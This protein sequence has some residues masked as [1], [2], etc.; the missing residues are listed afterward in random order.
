MKEA[1]TGLG[2]IGFIGLRDQGTKQAEFTRSLSIYS[3]LGCLEGWQTHIVCRV[4]IIHASLRAGL[5]KLAE[6]QR[7]L[8]CMRQQ[9]VVASCSDAP[10]R[11]ERASGLECRE[12]M[13]DCWSTFAKGE[14]RTSGGLVRR[15]LQRSPKRACIAAWY[16]PRRIRRPA[17]AWHCWNSFHVKGRSVAGWATSCGAGGKVSWKLVRAAHARH[18]A[19]R[20]QHWHDLERHL[21]WT[22]KPC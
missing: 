2:L 12:G 15:C 9:Q 7:G 17:A 8:A 20:E 14:M 10:Q 13:P 21:F 11:P 16:S 6:G 3:V 18:P 22:F 1:F 19:S 5:R 4:T